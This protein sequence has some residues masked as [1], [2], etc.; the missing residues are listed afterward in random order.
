MKEKAKEWDE[1][2]RRKKGKKEKEKEGKEKKKENKY[3]AVLIMN[4]IWRNFFY[5]SI[6]WPK[7]K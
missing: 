7:C 6:S 4:K 1:N 2:W 5:D 3:Q